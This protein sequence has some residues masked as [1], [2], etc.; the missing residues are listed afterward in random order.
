MDNFFSQFNSITFFDIPLKAITLAA[1]AIILTLLLRKLVTHII[2]RYFKHLVSKSDTEIDDLLLDAVDGPLRMAIIVL[3]LYISKSFIAEHISQNVNQFLDHTF[4]LLSIIVVFWLLYEGADIIISYLQKFSK[5]TETDLDDI[6]IPYLRRLIK[7]VLIVLVIVK[8]AEI[9]LGMSVAAL[10]G[11]LGGVGLTIGLVFKDIIANWFGCAVIYTDNL[12]REGDWVMLDDGGV[13]DADVEEIGLRSTKFRNFDKTVSAVPNSVIAQ[14]V[15][16]NWSRMHKR[17]IK[18]NLSIDG[19]DSE[20]IT[21]LV[22]GIREILSNDKDVHQEFH[23]VNFREISGNSRIIRL[24]FF[25]S[26][27][28]WKEHEQVRE[29]IYVKILKLLE[30]NGVDKL[31]YTIVD[32]SED[33]PR[34]YSISVDKK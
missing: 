33:R 15:V 30:S 12:F 11:V 22:D 28:V 13:V 20:G 6:L 8:F 3:G 5:K 32:L 27:T 31:A 34:D 10:F 24:Y 17:R 1:V 16:K 21:K 29:N 26:T 4:K 19:V 7:I 18:F 14:A 2:I 25:T 23:M 9:F